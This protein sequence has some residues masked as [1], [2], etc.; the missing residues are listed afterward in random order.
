M[1]DVVFH[2]LRLLDPEAGRLVGGMSVRMQGDRFVD[3]AAGVEPSSD[4]IGVD[5]GGR[6]MMPGLID[7]HVH[8]TSIRTQWA[9]KSYMHLLP[10]AVAAATWN[11]MKAMLL[12]G[13]TTAR[14]V[15]GADRGHREAVA[16]GIVI[17]P[18]LFV[19]GRSISQTGGHGDQRTR[20]DHPSPD[21]NFHLVPGH[22]GLRRVVDGVA[23][24]RRAVRD[25]I[26]LGADAIKLQVGGGVGSP[27][28]PVHFVQFSMDEL[29][30]A[31]EE[32][33]N[34]H[35]YVACHSYTAKAVRRA[36]L[37]GI[38]SIEHANFLDAPTA[39]LMVEHGAIMVPTLVAYEATMKYGAAQGYPP[40][41]LKKNEGVLAAGTTSLE[42]AKAAGVP[43]AFGT[44]LIGE[45]D[46]FQND[47]FEIRSRV[48]SNAEIIRQATIMGA[49]V[50]RCEGEIGV[51]AKGAY[52]DALVLDGNPL[53]DIG[54]LASGGPD[55]RVIL[56]AGKVVKDDRAIATAAPQAEGVP[57]GPR[58][59]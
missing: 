45:L 44:D 54:L 9:N 29:R 35:T 39:E 36:V 37:A 2:N 49:V 8:V 34:A 52:A 46:G 38:R 59:N 19:V 14:D 1:N 28:D 31:V 16:E 27:A 53:D 50:N 40:E 42:V 21:E 11:R 33:A 20:V 51:I 26:R 3:I 56:A 55:F 41:N 6:V 32:A 23:E 58:P 47:E 10:S 5:L 12:R 22:S 43:M 4:H 7:N 25:E 18:R 57:F 13:F 48:L 24:M 17:G 15:G 30:A